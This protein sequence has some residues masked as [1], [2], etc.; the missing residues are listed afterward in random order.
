MGVGRCWPT[1]EQVRP[2][3][4]ESAH[5]SGDVATNFGHFRRVPEQCRPMSR[6]IGSRS[7]DFGQSRTN[8]T[9]AMSTDVRR[10]R[11]CLGQLHMLFPTSQSFRSG[12]AH[13]SPACRH[14]AARAPTADLSEF[15]HIRPTSIMALVMMEA[16]GRP[17]LAQTER[18]HPKLAEGLLAMHIPDNYPG[19]PSQ[20]R[21]CP[22]AI[23]QLLK[24]SSGRLIAAQVRHCLADSGPFLDG[25]CVWGRG[26]AGMSTLGGSRRFY[27]WSIEGRGIRPSANGRKP[28]ANMWL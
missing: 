14:R 22:N 4:G 7:D 28:K 20:L 17:I 23:Q 24:G 18:N 10:H 27:R 1:L 12:D 15:R 25:A 6:E 26:S 3:S 16:L 11:P 2:I 13:V 19:E 5:V 8:S 9:G 21:R